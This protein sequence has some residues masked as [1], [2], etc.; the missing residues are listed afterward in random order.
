MIDS[1]SP[2]LAAFEA[3]A[4]PFTTSDLRA[5]AG[6]AST[7]AERID[8][9]YAWT[10]D[11]SADDA[12][13]EADAASEADAARDLW[14]QCVAD[15]DR[16]AFEERLD[17]DGLTW[18]DARAVVGDVELGAST[19]LPQW[20][21]GLAAVVRRV[22]AAPPITDDPLDVPGAPEEGPQA[23]TDASTASTDT[24]DVFGFHE[25]PVPFIHLLRPIANDARERVEA[26]TQSANRL[27]EDAWGDATEHLIRRLSQICS[28]ALQIKFAVH[29]SIE[30][31]M[32]PASPNAANAADE[33]DAASA[34]YRSF[35]RQM[36]TGGLAAFF[37][38]YA[39]AGRLVVTTLAYWVDAL[40]DFVERLDADEAVLRERL[41]INHPLG[42]VTSLTI[43]VSDPHNNHRFVIITTFETGARVV[44][45][46]RSL[47]L[48]AFYYQFLC[49]LND[50]DVG[51]PFQT[52]KV[53]DQ[54]TYGWVEFAE[55]TGCDTEAQVER[56]FERAGALICVVYALSGTDFHLENILAV[57][58][59]PMLVDLE[60]LACPPFRGIAAE[61]DWARAIRRTSN[62][63]VDSVLRTHLLPAWH[64]G[65][66]G[67]TYDQSGL[68]TN[69]AERFDVRRFR[70]YDV[71]TDRMEARVA[72]VSGDV[73]D[74]GDQSN[75]PRLNGAVVSATDYVPAITRGFEVTYDR[76]CAHRNTLLNDDD[77]PLC[78][79]SGLSSRLLYRST[80][81]YGAMLQRSLE[82]KYLTHGVRRSMEIEKFARAL[83]LNR[84]ETAYRAVIQAECQAV[85][86]L[87]VPLFS[88]RTDQVAMRLDGRERLDDVLDATG[89]S[90]VTD[91]IA[92][93]NPNDRDLQVGLIRTSFAAHEHV[94]AHGT[95]ST[96]PVASTPSNA[97]AL[98][99]D[100]LV[101]EAGRIATHL[102]RL[103][104]STGPEYATWL[105]LNS[106]RG[107]DRRR[108]QPLGWNLYDGALGVAL[109]LAAYSRVTGAAAPGRLAR[110]AVN[111][112][113]EGVETARFRSSLQRSMSLGGGL[114]LGS[115]VYGFTGLSRLLDD[116]G[117]LHTASHIA[118]LIDAPASNSASP[119]ATNRADD[120]TTGEARDSADDVTY[121]VTDGV[122][123]GILG[124]LAL[125]RETQ[126]ADL[127]VQATS[128]GHV[129]LDARVA[130][131]VSGCRAW[132]TGPGEG[133]D[134]PLTTGFAHGAAGIAYALTRLGDAIDS[135]T[136]LDAADE[137]YRYEHDVYVPE[138][139]NWPDVRT[140][141][142][143][144]AQREHPLWSTW[145]HGA[146]GVGFARVGSAH[147]SS[148]PHVHADLERAL[149][150]TNAW[151]LR[152]VDHLCC[153]NVG[154]ADL[155]LEAATRL[156]RPELADAARRLVDRVVDRATQRGTYGY[157]WNSSLYAPGFHQ[158]K[159]GIGYTLLRLVDP[160]LP[161][162]L[163]WEPFSRTPN[164]DRTR[165]PVSQ[166]IPASLS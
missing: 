136:F 112:I 72:T 39:V 145:C 127:L 41:S 137:A 121:D 134:R 152:T 144:L 57:G 40:T 43:G 100:D 93:L 28:K 27:T 6:R 124:L 107:T 114:G 110:Q 15:G 14:M 67:E 18:S 156:D 30:Q 105:S 116:D 35:V 5:L 71:N 123:G 65:S 64:V 50:R 80:K 17:W 129:L 84:S 1:R 142:D 92:S 29:R 83:T 22:A 75:A 69:Q 13:A 143:A 120:P 49:W 54:G 52:L 86:Q 103:S 160:S 74:L 166:P 115:L 117:M 162:V 60:M 16:E 81:V 154:R 111:A 38:E 146:T 8:G 99:P 165:S 104:F 140:S 77:S 20:T 33:S 66:E 48:E 91:R 102:E 23:K 9:P 157:G 161:S 11:A 24:P 70:W 45:K 101:A 2:C 37:R 85:E 21:Y 82:P 25:G 90:A 113:R 87:D 95:A 46:P 4:S 133:D 26:R 141:A 159:S 164:A 51:L 94:N 32:A 97:P 68:G 138:V 153:G 158:G 126:D 34:I 108:I 98:T 131:P 19:P 122:A 109:F 31:A 62:V 119:P 53:V 3:D 130:D 36:K 125:H 150:I 106:I 155:L 128:L 58:E 118:D 12:S 78:R 76:L 89:L 61:R 163:L 42:R 135:R 88:A 59:Q 63:I 56:Y 79:L 151:R 55:T 139:D 10:P 148:A 147:A 149:R 44:Y 47:A 96:L 132:R 7:L 73:T